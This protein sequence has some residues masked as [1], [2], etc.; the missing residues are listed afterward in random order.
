MGSPVFFAF[1]RK[2]YITIVL[3]FYIAQFTIVHS[4]VFYQNV[5]DIMVGPKHAD[6]T[7]IRRDVIGVLHDFTRKFLANPVRMLVLI[8][9]H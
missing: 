3:T 8:S 7:R 6:R 9:A 2:N 4:T 1:S 5:V